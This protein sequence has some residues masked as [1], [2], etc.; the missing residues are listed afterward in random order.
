MPPDG[1]A[2]HYVDGMPRQDE[3]PPAS[4]G[5]L[6]TLAQTARAQPLK[7]LILED[8]PT[9]AE[10]MQRELREADFTS[11]RVDTRADFVAALDS[12]APDIVLLADYKLPGF[13]GAE[14]LEYIRDT[15][16]EIP[17]VL[18]TGALGDEAAIQLLHAG[19]KDMC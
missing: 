11:R 18:V 14:A 13:S 9:D 12:F 17:V 2:L 16:P 3:A 7:V 1:L 5:P 19:A 6:P 4:V 15:H 10:L 8:E